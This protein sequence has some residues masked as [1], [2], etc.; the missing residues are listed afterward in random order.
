MCV[1]LCVWCT[2]GFC[3][4][5]TPN[6]SRATCARNF[7]TK[8][9]KVWLS[10]TRLV[11]GATV[12]L[13]RHRWVPKSIGITTLLILPTW[14]Q[15]LLINFKSPVWPKAIPASSVFSAFPFRLF[16]LVT[17]KKSISFKGH[18]KTSYT[19][20]RYICS[21]FAYPTITLASY[22][23]SPRFGTCL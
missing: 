17:H 6:H 10:L 12:C 7:L 18:S 22:V 5:T 3:L 23:P 13:L 11:V 2:C 4:R 19:L 8:F 14:Q 21:I 1:C 20:R 9:W 16:H 15:I